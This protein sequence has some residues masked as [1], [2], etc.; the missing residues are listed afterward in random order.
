MPHADNKITDEGETEHMNARIITVLRNIDL[1]DDSALQS[2]HENYD[3]QTLY[4]PNAPA[5]SIDSFKHI[6]DEVSEEI[7]EPAF[8]IGDELV[9]GTHIFPFLTQEHI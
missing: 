1:S 8:C 9:S 6:E 4:I 2:F 3:G 5:I 7:G